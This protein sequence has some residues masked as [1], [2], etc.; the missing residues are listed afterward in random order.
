MSQLF[1]HVWKRDVTEEEL[2][3]AGERVWNLGRLFNLREGMT[4][5]DDYLPEL[6]LTKPH[7]K[8]PSAGRIDRQ[9]GLRREDAGVLLAPRLGRERGPHRRQTRRARRRR[10]PLGRESDATR[11]DQQEEVHRVPHVRAG[12]L[13]L[14][15]GRLPALGRAPLLGV[16]PHDHRD[17]GPHVPADRLRQVPGRLPQRRHRHQ[18]DHGDAQGL[19]REQG[20]GRGL[21]RGL[22]ARRRRGQVHQ[23]R[24]VLRGVPHGRH[25]RAPRPRGRL[26]VRPLRRRAA[27]H[28]LLPEQVRLRRR[29]QGRQEGQGARA[30]AG[31]AGA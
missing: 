24:R 5:A 14:P 29:P 4:A 27:V 26:Q 13:G 31:T 23:L 7:K 12:V 28:R 1:K 17:Q 22:R 19:L 2:A 3:L 10:P 21:R 20:E 30:A 11:D 25:P 6:L 8:G 9:G 15:R 18:A 16:Q